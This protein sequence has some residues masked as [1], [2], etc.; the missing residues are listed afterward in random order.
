[1]CDLKERFYISTIANDCDKLAKKYGLG[2]EIA[3]FCTAANMDEHLEAVRET[4]L[5]HFRSADRFLL[6]A[7]FNEL[8]P[9]AIDPLALRLARKRYGQ[10]SGLAQK[11][12]VRRII[13]H[14]GYIPNVYFKSWFIEKSI[15]FWRDFL[16]TFPP[17]MKIYLENVMED[18][19]DMLM[20]IA[21][22][23]S[24]PR[25]CLCLD[26]GHANTELSKAPLSEWIQVFSKRLAHVHL[27]NN[28]GRLDLHNSLEN[29]T[30]PMARA[31]RQLEEIC[32]AP[33]YTLESIDARASV[34]WLVRER[35]ITI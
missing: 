29:G 12:G 18:S 25:F 1:M 5:S 23:I 14:S 27:H 11:Y 9:A 13:V 33:T 10:S 31:I 28:M 16:A 26:V 30:I 3:E 4:V 20:Q 34:D 17:D 15:S 35:F 22:G 7:P 6:H 32:D 2:I 21:E 8:S 19:P 24:D